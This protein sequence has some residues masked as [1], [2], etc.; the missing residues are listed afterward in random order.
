MDKEK[1][2]FCGACGAKLSA[3]MNHCPY[4]GTP[5]PGKAEPPKANPSV[6][7]SPVRTESALRLSS[8]WPILL[9]MGSLCTADLAPIVLAVFALV[10]TLKANDSYDRG[11]MGSAIAYGHTVRTLLIIGWIIFSFWM[12]MAL[13]ILII[14]A[15]AFA[16]LL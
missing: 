12:I 10:Y 4:C 8:L 11:D 3:K 2:P 5:N 14:F 16:A 9:L 13:I 15:G 7:A 6:T 1:G